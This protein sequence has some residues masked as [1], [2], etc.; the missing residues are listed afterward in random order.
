[1]KHKAIWLR[2]GLL[3]V[4]EAL[5]VGFIGGWAHDDPP[6]RR[7]ERVTARHEY[8]LHASPATKAAF[9]SELSLKRRYETQVIGLWVG[10]L[11]LLTVG[12]VYAYEFFR[13]TNDS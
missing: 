13:N 4:L 9:D 2:I 11:F 8:K 5:L 10:T 12:S 3:W 1:M 7:A 6:Y